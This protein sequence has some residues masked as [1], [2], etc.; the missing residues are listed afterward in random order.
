MSQ[1]QKTLGTGPAEIEIDSIKINERI[2][3]FQSSK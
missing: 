1:E 2:R 3:E